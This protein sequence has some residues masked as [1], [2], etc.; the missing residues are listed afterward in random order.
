MSRFDHRR[1]IRLWTA[2]H[3]FA[4]ERD[5][6]YESK[7]VDLAEAL[8][9]SKILLGAQDGRETR[10][11]HARLV[12]AVKKFNS[13]ASK[14]NAWSRFLSDPVVKVLTPASKQ[15][16]GSLKSQSITKLAAPTLEL[17]ERPGGPR[18]CPTWGEDDER[19]C[20][21]GFCSGRGRK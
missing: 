4:S 7:K 21:R 18:I 5:R 6:S 3:G 11:I 12:Q 8:G 10:H 9:R 1:A 16:I 2:I 13:L 14:G 17:P 15:G 20:S 19:A